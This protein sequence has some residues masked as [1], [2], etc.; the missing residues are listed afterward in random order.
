MHATF[1]ILGRQ[2]RAVLA[3]L[4]QVEAAGCEGSEEFLAFLRGELEEHLALEEAALFPVLAG[5]VPELRAGPLAVME[6]EHQELRN[7]VAELADA[8]RTHAAAPAARVLRVLVV[9]LRGHIDKEDHVL[10]PVAQRLLTAAEL[11]EVARR[12]AARESRP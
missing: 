12:T 7:L 5:C 2:H 8:L 11:A 3:R 1:E 10:F 6:A 4:D 9:L